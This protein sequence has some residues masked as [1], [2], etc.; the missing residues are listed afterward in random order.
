MNAT[1]DTLSIFNDGGKFKMADFYQSVLKA[2]ILKS[3]KVVILYII[4]KKTWCWTTFPIEL[5]SKNV[6]SLSKLHNKYLKWH[7]NR[8]NSANYLVEISFL[9]PK[10]S[11]HWKL[12]FKSVYHIPRTEECHPR[13]L[14]L[15]QWLRQIQNGRFLPEF[16]KKGEILNSSNV[17]IL[18]IVKKEI[19]NWTTFSI[20]LWSKRNLTA[21]STT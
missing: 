4:G 18:H 14:E 1:S 9:K 17:V 5:W 10:I 21:I 15:F 7:Q 13:Y 2:K 20:E 12:N 8:K 11:C 6:A 3:P 19:W 16:S